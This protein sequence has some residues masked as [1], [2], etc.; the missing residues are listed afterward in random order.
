MI[1]IEERPDFGQ[2]TTQSHT[3]PLKEHTR[4]QTHTGNIYLHGAVG[5]E[6]WGPLGARPL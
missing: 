3:E 5:G 4:I 1:G 6:N 2:L